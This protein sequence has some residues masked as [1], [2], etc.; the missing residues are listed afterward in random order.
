MGWNLDIGP[1][2][3]CPCGSGEK[4]KFCCLAKAKANRHGKY[5]VATVAYYGPDDKTT[6]KIVAG[7]IGREDGKPRLMKWT[8]TSLVGDAKV[9]EEMKRFFAKHGVKS[10]IM[11]EGNMGCPHEEGIDF[12][13]GHHCPVC[14]F[15]AGKQGTAQRA[16]PKT[17]Y[18]DEPDD[19]EDEEDGVGG[20]SIVEPDED[21]EEESEI[22]YDA[23]FERMG[24][25]IG[26]DEG[27]R[28]DALDALFKHLKAN[29]TLPCK[30]AATEDL[31]WEE[32]YVLGGW[33]RAEYKRLRKTQ[34]SYE[35][36][37]ELLGIERRPDSQW[38]LFDEDLGARV[39]RIPDGKEFV[40]GLAELKG[41]DKQ[42]PSW[43]LLE[44]YAVW[45]VNSR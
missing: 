40:L 27:D 17:G 24:K 13:A 1:Y 4:Y 12:P 19:D 18:L 11:T 20:F 22:D 43:Q 25:V 36:E 32:P 16:M 14:P 2:D 29:L 45:F 15:W 34:P 44:D 41:I 9:A 35:D 21:E 26:E 42:S 28:E 7:V 10:V 30:V 8:G 39:K 31:R 23:C 5:P 3:P 6:T 37:Y 33:S 38:M